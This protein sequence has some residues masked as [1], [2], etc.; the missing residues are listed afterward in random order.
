MARENCFRAPQLST[1]SCVLG[2]NDL[3]G[4]RPTR[5][6][7]CSEGSGH[8]G[9]GSGPPLPLRLW[10]RNGARRRGSSRAAGA[11]S[12][13]AARQ[14]HFSRLTV[15]RTRAHELLQ[16]VE[17]LVLV[18]GDERSKALSQIREMVT[19]DRPR[20][21]GRARD[22]PYRDAAIAVCEDHSE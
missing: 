11:A 15:S 14:R 17:R 10:G 3:E 19:D 16:L 9:P 2:A 4:S 1:P 22:R 5:P 18:A 7:V 20:H 8:G 12:T 21:A 6:W 13:P